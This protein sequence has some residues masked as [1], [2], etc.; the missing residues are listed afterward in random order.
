MYK[1]FLILAVCIMLFVLSS[2][3]KEEFVDYCGQNTNCNTCASS[4]GCS[5]CPAKNQCL[6]STSLKSTDTAC[7]PM[8]TIQSVFMCNKGEATVDA[9]IA[10]NALYKNQIADRVRPPNVYLNDE[11]EYSPETVMSGVSHLHHDLDMYYRTLPNTVAT[12]VEDNIRP[13]V[14]GILAENYYIQV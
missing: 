8:K 11:M 2:L 6:L 9:S 3:K 13:M 10:D 14:S 7:S 5:W 12:A 4:S 1:V